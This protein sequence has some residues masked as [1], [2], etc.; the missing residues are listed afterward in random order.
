MSECLPVN[1]DGLS[2]LT[3]A[4]TNE[5][6]SAGVPEG[7]LAVPPSASATGYGFTCGGDGNYYI[8]CVARYTGLYI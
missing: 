6:R 1:Y 4:G 8:Y 3:F 7:T 5:G 2:I